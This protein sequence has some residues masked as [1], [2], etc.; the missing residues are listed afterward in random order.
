MALG[1]V[2][3]ATEADAAHIARIQL[4][5]WRGAYA[6][7][8]PAEVLDSLEESWLEEQWRS[9]CAEPPSQEHQVFIAV[10]QAESDPSRIERVG[11]CAVGPYTDDEPDTAEG[12]GL[13][14]ELLVEPRFGRRGHGSRLLSA[15]VAH[16]QAHHVKVGYA[17]SFTRDAATLG[18]YK[19]A[20]WDV[21]GVRR[22]LDM[23]G[24]NV[25]Q[26]RLHADVSD[27]RD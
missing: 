17:W 16:W 20:G 2:R 18:F 24:R 7:I 23:A 9:A 22:T 11:F 6:S 1:Y 13:I 19:A 10:E 3:P 5:T 25:Q 15:A 14:T 4:T 21:D 26:L 12:A 27:A 8:V